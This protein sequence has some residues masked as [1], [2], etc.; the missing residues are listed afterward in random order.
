ML[1]RGEEN[2]GTDDGA[3]AE[4]NSAGEASSVFIE[5]RGQVIGRLQENEKVSARISDREFSPAIPVDLGPPFDGHLL[6]QLFG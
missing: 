2:Q 3:T 5:A 1:A 6:L 4:A